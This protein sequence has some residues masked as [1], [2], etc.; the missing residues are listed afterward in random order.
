MIFKSEMETLLEDT[1]EM[2]LILIY[3]ST[4]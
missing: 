2:S 3:D 1:M 4:D